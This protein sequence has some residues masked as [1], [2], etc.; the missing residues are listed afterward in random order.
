MEG[1]REGNIRSKRV[2]RGSRG[3]REKEQNGEDVKCLNNN[4]IF[5]YLQVHLH[6]QYTCLNHTA[7]EITQEKQFAY[8][9][10]SLW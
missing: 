9:N 3:E 2:R 4:P 10:N 6:Q 8:N 7:G 5:F 1:V